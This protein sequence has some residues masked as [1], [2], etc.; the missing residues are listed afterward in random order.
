TIQ[1]DLR[2]THALESKLRQAQKLEAIG[3]LA[4]GV[5]HDFNNILTVITGTIEILADA[6]AKQ[7][8]LAAITKMIDEAAGRGAEL[9]QHLLAF[10]RK[11]PLQPREIDIN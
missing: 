8:Q 4:G 3:R 5:A 2:E 10:A 6:V 9:T 7:P 11:Q 1:R